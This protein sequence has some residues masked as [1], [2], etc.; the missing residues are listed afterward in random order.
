MST[1]LR[2]GF[3]TGDPRL[4]RLPQFDERSRQYPIRTLLAEIP[5]KR[6]SYTWSCPVGRGPSGILPPGGALDQGREGACTGFSVAMEASARPVLIPGIT[7]DIAKLIYKRAQQLDEWAGEEYS[8]SS[9]LAALKAGME[10]GWYR[11]YRWALG[12]GAAQAEEDLALAVGYKGPAVLGTNWYEGMYGADSEGYLNVTGRAVGGHAYLTNAYSVQRDA[13]WVPNSW[14]GAGCGWLRR[15]DV[16]RLLDEDGEAA[17]PTLR[18]K[19]T[20]GR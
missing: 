3:V 2:G 6:R 20:E 15:T 4:D 12:P 14:G 18:T 11:E 7:N 1:Q 10:W 17:I 19:T 5:K 13:Y 8:G 9:V 16:I